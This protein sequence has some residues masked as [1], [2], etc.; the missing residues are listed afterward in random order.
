MRRTKHTK[1]EKLNIEKPVDLASVDRS[2]NTKKQKHFDKMPTD[3]VNDLLAL[4]DG[5]PSAIIQKG[6][7]VVQAAAL[8]R[9][10]P[11]ALRGWLSR[12]EMPS[13]VYTAVDELIVRLHRADAATTT[14]VVSVPQNKRV[15]LLNLLE[16]MELRF[17]DV[18]ML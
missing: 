18:A 8:L 5:S 14:I 4:M 6:K 1:K 2:L 10:R 3:R 11:Q 12:G 9:C 13:V 7:P 17:A 16:A 15:A